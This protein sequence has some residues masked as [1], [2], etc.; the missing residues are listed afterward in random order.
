MFK[1]ISFENNKLIN[2]GNNLFLGDKDY[3]VIVAAKD[4]PYVYSGPNWETKTYLKM[5]TF[6]VNGKQGWGVA[7]WI[8]RN[9]DGKDVK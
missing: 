1:L 6:K 8:Y 4:A 2:L 7:K 3:A 5:S 9:V